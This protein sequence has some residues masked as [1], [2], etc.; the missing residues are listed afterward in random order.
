MDEIL[1]ED[2]VKKPVFGVDFML[3]INP[4]N[5]PRKIAIYKIRNFVVYLATHLNMKIGTVSYDIFNSEESRQILEEMGF[6]VKYQSVDRTD[7]AYLDTIELMYEGR[8][9]MYDHPVFRREIFNVIHYRDKRKVDHPDVSSGGEIGSKDLSDSLVGAIELGLQYKISEGS[10]DGRTLN[11]FLT[12]NET[13]YLF[14]PDA[15]SVEEMVDRQID[16]MIDDMEAGLESGGI[17]F[18]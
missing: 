8:L 1:E 6:N 15:M 12:A 10:Q 9:R 18:F 14:E 3:H 11:D 13:R 2:G 16:D 4:P 5:P 7:K 17:S